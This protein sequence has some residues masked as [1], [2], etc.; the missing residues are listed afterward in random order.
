MSIVLHT[1]RPGTGKTY[2]LTKEIL[3][4]LKKGEV[5]YCNYFIKWEGY[6]E[7]EDFVKRWLWKLGIKKKLKKYPKENL[8]YW[9]KLEDLYNL[10]QGIIA[11]DEAHIYMRSRGW[12][13]LPE[14]MERKLA[15]HRKDGL[16]IW[17]TVQAIERIDKI[18]RELVDFWFVYENHGLFF[19]RYEFDIDSDKTKKRPIS[20]SWILKK[21][22]IFESYD[23]LQKL[24]PN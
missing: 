23:T 9:R 21:K 16:H 17:G 10:E 8:K 5:V 14:E 24:N 18:F 13:K 6:S 12:D 2:N 20:K 11:M 15:Q 22:K 19:V 3:K 7:R 1:G 4:A